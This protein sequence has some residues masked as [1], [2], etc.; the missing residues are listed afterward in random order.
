MFRSDFPIA[1][2]PIVF[3]D[4]SSHNALRDP[5]G[6][7]V[8]HFDFDRYISHPELSA[9]V[10]RAGVV[11][12]RDS[13]F[14]Y[15]LE[16]VQK[17][18]LLFGIYHVIY[19]NM[20]VEAH[21][22]NF[23]ELTR[24]AS[25]VNGYLFTAFDCERND[26]GLAP[27][28]VEAILRDIVNRFVDARGE[29]P[30]IYTRGE[31]WERNVIASR[32]GWAANCPLWVAHYFP[33]DSVFDVPTA[34]PL[35]P[36]DWRSRPVPLLWQFTVYSGAGRAKAFGTQSSAIDF[37]V[38]CYEGGT[39]Q[40]FRRFFG[41]DHARVA[42]PPE[43]PPPEAPP[44]A[45]ANLPQVQ[46]YLKVNEAAV[47]IRRGPGA[48]YA[49]IGVLNRGTVMPFYDEQDGYLRLSASRAPKPEIWICAAYVQR[50]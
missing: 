48:K 12:T 28:R 18:A 49:I 16:Q 27:A 13:E 15:N 2:P 46:G 32:A 24:L 35:L 6:R 19:P 23:I 38:F 22:K 31:W 1:S 47:Y 14:L 4:I 50:Y 21:V 40:A 33:T 20:G 9:I 10:L 42:P 34:R 7:L 29:T 37:N 26:S 30:V 5:N 45:A 43:A 8:K 17:R 44:P 3:A 41:R 39:P 36:Q 11:S 25:S